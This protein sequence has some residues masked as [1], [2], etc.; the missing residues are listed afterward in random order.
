MARGTEQTHFGYDS[1]PLEDK[2]RRVD[3][4]FHQGLVDERVV[5]T[6]PAWELVRRAARDA[7]SVFGWPLD[8][9]PSY[10]HE[11]VG[12]RRGSDAG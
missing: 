9:P 7:L 8:R 6:D 11:Y 5:L 3:D 4:V 10:A 2:Q 12:G 1:V